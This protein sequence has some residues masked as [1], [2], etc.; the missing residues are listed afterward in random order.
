[1]RRSR[2]S[3]KRPR[4][5]RLITRR[6]LPQL[7]NRTHRATSPTSQP[8]HPKSTY[9]LNRSL[10][11]PLHL[12]TLLPIHPPRRRLHIPKSSYMLDAGLPS[13]SVWVVRLFDI[14]TVIIDTHLPFYCLS[15]NFRMH[16]HSC[17]LPIPAGACYCYMTRQPLGFCPHTNIYCRSY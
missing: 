5:K 11:S 7:V 12:L 4:L 9:R 13:S 17:V 2:S 16:P 1:M 15:V 10:L 6:A 8:A 14:Q 3:R